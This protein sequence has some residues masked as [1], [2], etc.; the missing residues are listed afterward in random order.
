MSATQP[1]RLA[2]GLEVSAFLRRAEADGGFGM[3][4]QK[5]DENRGS[6]L[7]VVLERGVPAAVLERALRRDGSY[8]W[9]PT[10]L[11][12]GDSQQVA[13]YVAR[14]RSSDPDCWI[15][16][17]DVPLSERFIAETIRMT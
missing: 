17:L 1:E 8:D 3:V 15:I 2:P 12:S 16:E 13:Q 4:L 9:T 6:V 7:L 10:R 14:R 5:G 11:A